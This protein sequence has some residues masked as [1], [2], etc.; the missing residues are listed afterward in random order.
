MSERREGHFKGHDE[1][2]LFYQSWMNPKVANTR[3]TLVITHGI[4]EHSE[5]Y[6]PTAEALV[7]MGWR[8]FAWDLRGHGRSDGKRGFILDFVDY[9][10]DLTSF[11]EFLTSTGNI[12]GPF[13]LIGHSMGGLITMRSI[14]DDA[15]VQHARPNAIALSSPAFGIGVAVPMIKDAAARVLIKLLPSVTLYNEVR[16]ENLTRDPERL[17]GYGLDPLRHEK[18]SPGVY[19]GMLDSMKF[20]NDRAGTLSIPILI[21]AAGQEKIVSLPAIKEF[22]HRLGS[23]KKELIVYDDSFHEIYNDLDRERVFTDLDGFLAPLM[24][25]QKKA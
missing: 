14:F 15:S 21:Q 16:Y 12:S 23:I 5:C 13:A 2:E 6:G 10:R 18:I 11:L 1:V 24:S 20:V 7:A 19:L 22:Y 3:G 17:K 9:A 4:S 25:S 8:V